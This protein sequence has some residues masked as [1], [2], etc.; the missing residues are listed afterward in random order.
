MVAIK[1]KAIVDCTKSDNS[2]S[3]KERLIALLSVLWRT[4]FNSEDHHLGRNVRKATG[5]VTVCLGSISHEDHWVEMEILAQRRK[6]S[7]DRIAV[8]KYMKG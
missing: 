3:G 1:T 6:S 4:E 5:M 2:L 8:I 7:G